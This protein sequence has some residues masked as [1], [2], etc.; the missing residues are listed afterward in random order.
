MRGLAND[1]FAAGRD[2]SRS[3]RARSGVRHEETHDFRHWDV[4]TTPATFGRVITSRDEWKRYTIVV[5]SIGVV[6]FPVVWRSLAT[7]GTATSTRVLLWWLCVAAFFVSYVV[8]TTSRR[9]AAVVVFQLA[10][11]VL[12]LLANWLV[13]MAI[14]GVALTGIL[15][16]IAAGGLAQLRPLLAVTT[17]VAQC[18]GLLAIYVAAWPP[19]IAIAAATAYA[20]M[21]W[22]L[23]SFARL[24]IVER[25][26]RVSLESAMRDLHATQAML[27]STVRT[28]ERSELARDLHDVVGHHLVALGLQ[29]DATLAQGG[30]EE[31]ARERIS[32]ARHLVRL[33][34]TDVR[35]VVS[36]LRAGNA[37]DLGAALGNLATDGPGPAVHVHV[38]E[39]A[40]AMS[41]GMA[42]A[43]LRCAQ[44]ALTNARKHADARTVTI[45]LDDARLAIVDDGCG[46]GAA[47]AGVGLAS[48]RERCAAIG[49]ELGV[50][51]AESG[52]TKV[53][54]RWPTEVSR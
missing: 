44:E 43:L 3:R 39:S 49:C 30:I 34:L 10:Q 52:G 24:A 25:E 18:V 28:A 32:K 53:E 16:V 8:A 11:T 41:S 22:I 27:A 15:L 54:I 14:E 4:P 26:R 12:A 23:Y 47:P 17:L 29:L 9:S 36:D 1:V 42:E 48:M 35:E 37:V 13:P 5:A 6:A 21:Q 31:T 7:P 19:A 38:S 51:N 46:I 20:A 2:S 40:P 45:S 50:G 33:V